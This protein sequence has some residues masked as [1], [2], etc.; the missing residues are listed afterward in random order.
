VDEKWV[1][2]IGGKTKRG[3]QVKEMANSFVVQDDVAFP[4]GG[5]LPLWL[6][7]FLY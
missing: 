4:A 3:G 6:F 1:F 2:E 5:A 7:G